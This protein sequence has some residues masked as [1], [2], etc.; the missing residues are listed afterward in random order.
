MSR[1]LILMFVFVCSFNVQAQDVKEQQEDSQIA[2]TRGRIGI[3]YSIPDF[4][5]K[6]IDGSIIGDHLADMLNYLL[7]NYS[8]GSCKG[9]LMSVIRK[10]YDSLVP[11]EIKNLKVIE[12]SKTGD[13]ITV[14]TKVFLS[15][16]EEGISNL[17]I[18]FVFDKGISQNW[19][20]NNLFIYLSRAC[21]EES[22][23]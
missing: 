20:I 11:P 17:E 5:T 19:L 1:L 9:K 23:L 12:I 16:N 22:R 10:Q 3:D 7:E 14:K 8:K 6:K 2:F 13:V 15:K 18:P 4:S 21:Q